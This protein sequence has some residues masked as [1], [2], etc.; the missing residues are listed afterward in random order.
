MFKKAIIVFALFT[1]GNLV[2]IKV[3]SAE[4][5]SVMQTTPAANSVA[6]STSSKIA[7]LFSHELDPASI[8]ESSFA[9]FS[10]YEGRVDGTYQVATQTVIFDPQFDFLAGDMITVVLTS[11]VTGSGADPLSSPHIWTFSVES[12][13]IT[14]HF[15][16]RET[17]SM[18]DLHWSVV[19]ADFNGDRAVDLAVARAE[20]DDVAIMLNDGGSIIGIDSTYPVSFYPTNV[21]AGDFDNDG[22]VELAVVN[23]GHDTEPDSTVTV[24]RNLGDGTF[25]LVGHFRVGLR[26]RSATVA[27][28]NGDTYADIVVTLGLTDQ[29]AILTNLHDGS[30]APAVTVAVGDY[31]FSVAAADLDNDGDIDLATANRGENLGRDSTVTILFNDGFGSFYHDSTHV[32]GRTPLDLTM[33][34]LDGYGFSDLAVAVASS[35]CISVLFNDGSGVLRPPITYKVDDIPNSV[36]AVDLDGDDDL[37]L[38]V[39]CGGSDSISVLVNDGQ[40]AFPLHFDYPTGAYPWSVMAADFDLDGYLDLV[41]ADSYSRKLSI[42]YKL[43]CYDSDLDGFGDPDRAENECLPDNCPDVYNPRQLDVDGDALADSCDNCPVVAN[44]DQSDEDEDGYG[45]LCDNCSIH[46]N[47]EQVDT[48]LDGI[49][50][51]CD[52]CVTIANADQ[53]DNDTD[54]EGDLCDIDNDNDGRLDDGDGSGIAGDYPCFRFMIEPCDDNCPFVYNPLQRDSDRDG[55]GDACDCCQGIRG[56]A[57][58]DDLDRINIADITFLLDY[59]FGGSGSVEPPCRKEG[60]ANGD[61]NESINI[62]DVTYLVEYLFGIPLGPAPPPCP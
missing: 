41:T 17:H 42:A 58:D 56:N 14:G 9:V 35:D 29:I 44:S 50:D 8:N 22:A 40:G 34:D 53:A 33:G 2:T 57:N 59:L 39:S 27:D 49:G 15:G 6:V 61:S 37:D 62:S 11:E 55:I 38:A 26:P 19:T 48:D 30:F 25:E 46:Y 5:I 45:D 47:P 18:G 12:E 7:V 54:G 60:N 43:L 1:I 31:P 20:T 36:I 4:S 52:N 28:I 32:A 10:L 23:R 16:A 21:S 24:L 13:E 51:L 3:A